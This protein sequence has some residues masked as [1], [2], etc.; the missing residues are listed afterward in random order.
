MTSLFDPTDLL[1]ALERADAAE[2]QALAERQRKRREA[3]EPAARLYQQIATARAE[4]LTRET[5]LLDQLTTA[6][7][8][9]KKN[10]APR[11]KLDQLAIEPLTTKNTA[12]KTTPRRTRTTKPATRTAN[13]PAPADTAS[14]TSSPPLAS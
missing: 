3:L 2:A 4:F 6:L 1:A 9:A 5:E 7:K 13:T 10:G 8:E 14:E 12:R 11:D